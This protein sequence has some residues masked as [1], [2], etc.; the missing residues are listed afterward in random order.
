MFAGLTS[1]C[2]RPAR[3]VAS[4]APAICSTIESI[5]PPRAAPPV[6]QRLEAG[7][8]DVAHGDVEHPAFLARVVDRHDVRVFQ[9]CGHPRFAAEAQLGLLVR[10]EGR[11]EHLEGHLSPEPILGEIDHAH[12][13]APE[14]ALD[15]EAGEG[16]A[17]PRRPA[18][19][20][21][22]E[23]S[24][25]ATRLEAR[26]SRGSATLAVPFMTVNR[27]SEAL[28]WLRIG[29]HPAEADRIAASRRG[30]GRPGRA[31]RRSRVRGR[32]G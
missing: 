2:T 20:S 24:I 21:P 17:D 15:P 6:D 32:P 25:S 18:Q 27:S 12:S 1:R 11:R 30:A 28:E 8:V 9:R 19:R 29:R 14:Q 4:R 3:C 31:G 13:A 5:R 23:A 7:A 10:R 16:R 22:F 26:R